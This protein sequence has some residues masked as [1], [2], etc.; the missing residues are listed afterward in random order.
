MEV[1]YIKFLD[2]L[3]SVVEVVVGFGGESDNYIE[4]YACVRYVLI[5]FVDDVVEEIGVVSS[6]H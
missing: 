2:E 1:R 5:Y 4:C 6:V 3:E